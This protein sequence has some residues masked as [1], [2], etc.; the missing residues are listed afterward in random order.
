MIIEDAFPMAH[1][2][3]L[4]PMTEVFMEFID[5]ITDGKTQILGLYE[6]Y[7]KFDLG[8]QKTVSLP[9]DNI[10]IELA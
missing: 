3:P 8:I 6:A 7:L 1:T 9:I 5:S 10:L 2:I 4:A